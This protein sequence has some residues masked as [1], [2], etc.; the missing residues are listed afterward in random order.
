M[1]YD[2]DNISD[3]MLKRIGQYCK[4]D[5]FQP[6]VIGKVS[7]AAKSLCMWV[8]AMEVRACH[9]YRNILTRAFTQLVQRERGKRKGWQPSPKE[10]DFH[11]FIL[12]LQVYGRVY[13]VV[14]PKRL[15]LKSATAQLAEKQAALAEAQDKLREV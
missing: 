7:L 4:Q 15:Q 6:E 11:V 12:F 1:N 5:D 13:R 8:R 3:R 2:K 9:L 10:M 14:E